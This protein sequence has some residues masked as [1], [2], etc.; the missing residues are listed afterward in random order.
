MSNKPPVREKTLQSEVP[1]IEMVCSK[2]YP[3]RKIAKAIESALHNA[4]A[5]QRVRGE[6]FNL[7][8]TDILMLKETLS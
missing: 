7:S 1:A 5:E 4:Y 8:P 2:K 3:S 6:W